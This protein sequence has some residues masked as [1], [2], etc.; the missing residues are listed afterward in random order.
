MTS[1]KQDVALVDA[2]KQWERRSGSSRCVCG[3]QQETSATTRKRFESSTAQGCF[4][5]V[6]QEDAEQEEQEEAW[7]IGGH[8]INTE[9]MNQSH[10]QTIA[11]RRK[12]AYRRPI[13][14]QNE[15]ATRFDNT[16]RLIMALTEPFHFALIPI[17][18]N[19]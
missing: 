12:F 16:G 4:Q 3:M 9:E 10:I 11:N 8:Q 5:E 7:L 2:V 1:S 17:F 6:A 18:I 19:E 13:W 15:F 14:F